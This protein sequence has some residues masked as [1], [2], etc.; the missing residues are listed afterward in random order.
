MLRNYFETVPGE[1]GGGGRDRRVQ[2]AADIRKVIL[3]LAAPAIMATGLYV[4]MIA[5]KRFIGP[6]RDPGR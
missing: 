4:F 2:P 6:L 5:W 1:P 3:P